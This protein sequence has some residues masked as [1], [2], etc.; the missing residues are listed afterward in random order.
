MLY[1]YVRASVW[2]ASKYDEKCAYQLVLSRKLFVCLYY[3]MGDVWQRRCDLLGELEGLGLMLLRVG[4]G[5]SS[6]VM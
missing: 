4:E 5:M 2:M 6:V 1:M 3:H